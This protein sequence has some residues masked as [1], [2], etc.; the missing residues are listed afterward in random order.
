[1]WSCH[2]T[3]N[4]ECKVKFF[5]LLYV[6]RALQGLCMLLLLR[7]I[8][9]RTMQVQRHI[10]LYAFQSCITLAQL[11]AQLF[12]RLKKVTDVVV[13]YSVDRSA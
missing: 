7:V 13:A 10:T 4:R 5:V 9:H 12:A 8:L 1:M 2:D 6:T 3:L 11:A